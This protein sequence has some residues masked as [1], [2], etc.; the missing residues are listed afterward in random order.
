MLAAQS[1]FGT[2]LLTVSSEL[3]SRSQNSSSDFDVEPTVARTTWRPRGDH[4][5]VFVVR[6]ARVPA[7]R[8]RLEFKSTIADF[9]ART[10]KFEVI[11]AV[12]KLIE[13]D[14]RLDISTRPRIAEIG[15]AARHNG[16]AFAF[17][18]P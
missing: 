17:W 3:I 12:V 10:E 9:H 5:M 16:E 2:S 13:A 7:T 18:F 1:S 8:V 15:I 6:P 4:R 14:I 11:L